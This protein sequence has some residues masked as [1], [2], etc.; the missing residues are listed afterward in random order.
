MTKS[1][2][3]KVWLFLPSFL[4]LLTTLMASQCSFAQGSVFSAFASKTATLTASVLAE[5]QKTSGHSFS[6]EDAES[7]YQ[8]ARILYRR[9]A[10]ADAL[11]VIKE[12]LKIDPQNE[13]YV[14]LKDAIR[15]A[16]LPEEPDEDKSKDEQSAQKPP[17]KETKSKQSAKPKGKDSKRKP[18][19]VT[20][21]NIAG[22]LVRFHWCP[23]G[24]FM[25]G[26]PEGEGYSG[27]TQHKVTLTKGFWIA[28]TETTQG[29]WQAVMGKAP[30]WYEGANYPV[31]GVSWNE[32]QNFIDILNAQFAPKG[33]RYALPTEA[34]WEYA[35]R[36]GT[37]TAFSFGNELNGEKANC[38]G[39]A[40][41]GTK[42]KGPFLGKI[43]LVGSYDPN[44]W[45]LYDMHGNVLEWC[46]DCYDDYPTE[47]VVDPLVTTGARRVQ[48]G[49]F[50]SAGANSCRSA[51]RSYSM[52]DSF[53]VNPPGFRLI[54]IEDAK[55]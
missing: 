22:V 21:A 26:S 27:E 30:R 52:P 55:K 48:R 12:A 36:A 23:P 28:E 13:D 43:T 4:F 20:T 3:M 49:G 19:E 15:G 50:Y 2:K 6:N 47:A 29:L 45:G 14:I 5:N 46:A 7:A 39:E 16:T 42:K 51:A 40:P 9:K 11:K 53:S 10:Y 41:Y 31:A 38:D 25:M 35:C 32:C 1:Q 18:G 8:E 44:P 37:T 33:Y 34:Q 24:E 54:V 17:K